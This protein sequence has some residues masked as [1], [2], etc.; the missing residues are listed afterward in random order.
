M[1]INMR[2]RTRL[3]R[4]TA[5]HSATECHRPVFVPG[6]CGLLDR[7]PGKVRFSQMGTHTPDPLPPFVPPHPSGRYRQEPVVQNFSPK[8][9]FVT[10]VATVHSQYQPVLSSRTSRGAHDLVTGLVFDL[11]HGPWVADVLRLRSKYEPARLGFPIE[12]TVVGSSGLGWFNSTQDKATLLRHVGE[13]ARKFPPFAFRFEEVACFPGTTVYYLS[14]RE[15]KPFFD[16]QR[17]LQ[18]CGLIYDPTPFSFTPHCTIVSL[19]E[20]SQEAHAEIMA[21]PVP[22][23]E[24]W[25]TSVSFYAVDVLSNR[26]YQQERLLLGG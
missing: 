9:S 16:F 22:D 17:N 15:S 4:R 7:I 3:I 23:T 19:A 8:Q 26:C 14:P 25:V 24:V 12:I 11:P 13:V 5:I 10:P 6:T 21:C 18:D 2:W 20:P 1:Y